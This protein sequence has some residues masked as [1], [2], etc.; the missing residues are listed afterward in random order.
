VPLRNELHMKIAEYDNNNK[1]ADNYIAVLDYIKKGHQ[2]LYD[3]RYQIKSE[4][5]K[6]IINSYSADIQKLYQAIIAVK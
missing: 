3:M 1:A 5:L 2:Q 4:A 6:S